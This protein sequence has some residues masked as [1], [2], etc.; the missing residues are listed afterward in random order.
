MA[1]NDN[2]GNADG[3]QSRVSTVPSPR[4]HL[5]SKYSN[6]F[7]PAANETCRSIQSTKYCA[8][9]PGRLCTWTFPPH[10][11]WHA[12]AAEGLRSTYLGKT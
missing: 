6:P 8:R 12:L 10:L 11:P 7:P 4:P 5:S 1:A 9:T 2:R 3:T